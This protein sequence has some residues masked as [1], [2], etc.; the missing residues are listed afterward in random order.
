MTTTPA[1][2]AGATKAQGVFIEAF[3]T[4]ALVLC[5]LFL[6]VEKHKSTFLA[7]VGIGL[8][9]LAG[10][11]FAVVFTGASMNTARAFGPAVFTGFDGDHWIYW[12]GPTIVELSRPPALGIVGPASDKSVNIVSDSKALVVAL[13]SLA[14]ALNN[15]HPSLASMKALVP[16]NLVYLSSPFPPVRPTRYLGLTKV[17]AKWTLATPN[18]DH[19]TGSNLTNRL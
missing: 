6:A 10:H 17:L 15:P 5:V 13:S 12:V 4:C 16:C 2:G 18:V 3:V 8:T 19:D 9:L 14:L 1:L 11:L 7:P